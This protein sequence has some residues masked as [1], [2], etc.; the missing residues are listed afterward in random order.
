MAFLAVVQGDEVNG[1]AIGLINPA[2]PAWLNEPEIIG[3]PTNLRTRLMELVRIWE[4]LAPAPMFSVW[5]VK[6]SSY[7]I[8]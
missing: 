5:K 8:T 1:D 7:L 6:K 4:K 2:V 3:M